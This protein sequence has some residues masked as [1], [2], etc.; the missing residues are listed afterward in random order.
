MH[1]CVGAVGTA[2]Q[3]ATLIGGPIVYGYYRRIRA[4]LGLP[5]NSYA[6]VQARAAAEAMGAMSPQ[7]PMRT[8]PAG[9]AA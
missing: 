7:R 4:A 6:A 9:A 2:C 8:V 1:A 3:A 5:D